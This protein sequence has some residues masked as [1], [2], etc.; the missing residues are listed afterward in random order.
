MFI[1]LAIS[2]SGGA[3][4]HPSYEIKDLIDTDLRNIARDPSIAR[5]ISYL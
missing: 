2:I 1:A 4:I 5:F 3:F